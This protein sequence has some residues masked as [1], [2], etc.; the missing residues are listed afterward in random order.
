[1]RGPRR[2][3]TRRSDTSFS[4]WS[5]MVCPS[6]SFT[7]LKRSMSRRTIATPCALLEGGFGP[8]AEEVAV[9]ELGQRVV[10]GLISI[11]VALMFQALEEIGALQA[12]DGV[13]SK[14]LEKLEVFVI[15][16]VL[17][18]VAVKRHD[19]ADRRCV[20]SSVE[21][22]R[23]GGSHQERNRCSRSPLCPELLW[24]DA[25]PEAM[26]CAMIDDSSRP[27]GLKSRGPSVVDRNPTEQFG[28]LG[29]HELR[30]TGTHDRAHLPQYV[31]SH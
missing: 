26:V 1:M 22:P 8:V 25:T 23:P 24:S 7:S 6:V 21:Q 17:F 3:R 31:D 11:V 13:R 18:L 28:R 9:R 15:E 4:R 2:R 30:P 29:Q 12:R 10:C 19:G 20:R 5:P 27:Y 16:A 14:S